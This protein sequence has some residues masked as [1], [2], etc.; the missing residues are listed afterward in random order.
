MPVLRRPP[1]TP[2]RRGLP[3]WVLGAALLATAAGGYLIFAS[4]RDA[5]AD[6]RLTGDLPYHVD[7]LVAQ[8]PGSAPHFSDTPQPWDGKERVTLLL[9][10]T[11]HRAG[12]SDA[13]RSDTLILLTLDPARMTAGILSIPRDLWVEI[14]GFGHAKINTAYYNGELYELP[15]GGP[16]LAV[17]TVEAFLG[18]PIHG[19]VVLHFDAFERLID[20]MGGIDV[21]VAAP[22]NDPEYPDCCYGFEPFYLPAGRQ[23]LTGHDALRY[24][25]TRHDDDDLARAG[26]QQQVI[27]AV[28]EKV[29]SLNMLPTLVTRAPSLLSTLQDG[30]ATSLSLD[31]LVALAL[32]AQQVPDESIRSVV[33]D[34]GYAEPA[35][36][37]DG[38]YILRPFPGEIRR[39][40]DELFGSTGPIT[41]SPEQDL[42]ALAHQEAAR[43]IVQNG[44]YTDGLASATATYL[45]SLGLNVVDAVTAPERGDYGYATTVIQDFAGKPYTTRYLADVM[46]IAPGGLLSGNDPQA[47]A[48]IIVIVGNDWVV[49]AA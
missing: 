34:Y 2:R 35:T 24:A 6:W 37:P 16:A 25:R 21:D 43:I 28:R 4:V 32:L 9:M 13:P 3:T 10:G 8:E 18:V 23:H 33:I 38:L 29:L 45:T 5:V 30:V 15:G 46:G 44:T 39:L 41:P 22:I 1:D 49:P 19:Y 26:R 31:D 14:P 11:D 42:A 36:S 40:R 27:L 48:D 20:E 7:S 17:Q 12:E 47:R